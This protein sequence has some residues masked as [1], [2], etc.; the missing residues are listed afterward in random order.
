[1]ISMYT[2]DQAT[3][4]LK[5]ASEEI[6]KECIDKGVVVPNCVQYILKDTNYSNAKNLMEAVISILKLAREQDDNIERLTKEITFLKTLGAK[7][8]DR[9][10]SALEHISDQLDSMQGWEKV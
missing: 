8:E 3:Q 7:H 9:V 5:K 2:I 10:V 1:M 4:E 6:K